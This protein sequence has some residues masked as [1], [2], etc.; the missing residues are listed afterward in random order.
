MDFWLAYQIAL[1]VGLVIVGA[2]AFDTKRTMD[3]ILKLARL[4][5]SDLYDPPTEEIP[6]TPFMRIGP[7]SRVP[8]DFDW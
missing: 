4:R 5:H 6:T 2:W 7:S 8:D 3:R 1:G